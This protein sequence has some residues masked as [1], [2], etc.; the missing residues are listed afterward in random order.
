MTEVE[1]PNH[2]MTRTALVRTTVMVHRHRHVLGLRDGRVYA[3]AAVLPIV[4]HVVGTESFH[5]S[6]SWRQFTKNERGFVS[7]GTFTSG[8]SLRRLEIVVATRSWRPP[9]RAAS[10]ATRA[11]HSCV[12][13]SCGCK[14]CLGTRCAG[15]RARLRLRAEV[16]TTSSDRRASFRARAHMARTVSGWSSSIGV[17]RRTPTHRWR[18]SSELPPRR[19]SHPGSTPRP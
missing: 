17:R 2:A 19:R 7:D 10:T 1:S 4:N 15:G 5:L 18:P 14:A 12:R 3:I 6:P 11:K 13:A 8:L 16:A 9:S